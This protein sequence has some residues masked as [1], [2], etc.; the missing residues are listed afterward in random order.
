M[1][2]KSKEREVGILQTI[3]ATKRQ[4]ILIFFTQGIF[5]TFKGIFIGLI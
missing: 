4:I 5:V 3:G 1:T 2:V